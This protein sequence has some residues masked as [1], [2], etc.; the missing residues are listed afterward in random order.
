MIKKLAILDTGFSGYLAI[1]KKEATKLQLPKIGES[2]T[3]LANNS[4]VPTP[5]H[6]AKV[7]FMSLAEEAD[8]LIPVNVYD[9]PIDWCLGLKLINLFATRNKARFVLDF[10]K[11][12]LLFEKN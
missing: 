11:Q 1:S 10:Q 6:K 9:K 8:F 12:V 7:S 4:S 3:I 5:I 2:K